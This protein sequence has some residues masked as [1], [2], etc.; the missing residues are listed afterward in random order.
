MR[1]RICR[2][3][4]SVTVT[5]TVKQ[6]A[7]K[8]TRDDAFTSYDVSELDGPQKEVNVHGVF[9]NISPMK[10]SSRNPKVQYFDGKLSDGK[11]GLL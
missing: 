11:S 4:K 10:K 8:R 6:M 2:K 9:L 7:E 3:A 1:V 5:V